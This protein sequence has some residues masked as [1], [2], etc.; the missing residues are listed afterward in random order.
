LKNKI[1]TSHGW[2]K[3][4]NGK[5]HS[6]VAWESGCSHTKLFKIELNKGAFTLVDEQDYSV[7]TKWK[8]KLGTSGY[9]QRNSCQR[10]EVKTLFLHRFLMSPPAG[11]SVD[12]INGNRLDNRK[13]NLRICTTQ[14][15]LQNSKPR[16]GRKFKGVTKSRD[17]WQARIFADGRRISLG[18]FRSPEEAAAAYNEAAKTHYGEF[19]WLNEVPQ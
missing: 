2:R 18:R 16:S 11:L 19:A 12:H 4:L 10:G 15:N 3:Y 17:A 13:H 8:W 1:K 14:Q 5:S 7:L 9:A 6:N